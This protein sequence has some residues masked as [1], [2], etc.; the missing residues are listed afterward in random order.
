MSGPGRGKRLR[1]KYHSQAHRRTA[2]T[3][4]GSVCLDG[5]EILGLKGKK[6]R[7][8]Y[9]KLQMVFQTPQDSFDPR[10]TLGDGIM[11][12]MRNRG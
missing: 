4:Q 3:G 11:E 7:D 8:V 12:S 1:K 9:T 10:W 2:G 6:K 5:E